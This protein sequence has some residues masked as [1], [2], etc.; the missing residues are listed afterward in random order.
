MIRNVI[1]D[2]GNVMLRFEPER[3]MTVVGVTDEQDRKILY[4]EIYDSIEWAMMDRGTLTDEEASEIIMTRVPE[5][6]KDKVDMLVGNW[7]RPIIP[8]KGMEEL[9][10]ELKEKGYGIYLLSNASLRQPKYWD[11]VPGNEYF[12][13]TMVSAYEKL[14]KPQPEIY[15][16]FLERFK[17]K[18]EECIFIDD[19]KVNAEGAIFCGIQSIVFHDDMEE[20]REKLSQILG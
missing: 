5:H 18:A 13:G 17:L 9:V 4:R 12:D 1:F 3:F 2:M 7:D 15:I 11:S 8:V 20:L 16:R 19:S 10:K 14:V 6:L